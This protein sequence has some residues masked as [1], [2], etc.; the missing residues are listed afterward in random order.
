MD[1]GV[2]DAGLKFIFVS[3]RSWSGDLV[4]AGGSPGSTGSANA[5]FLCNTLGRDAGLGWFTAL[6]T[7]PGR[8]L[9]ASVPADGPWYRTDGVLVFATRDELLRGTPRV[10]INLDE[11]G[12]APGGYGS[13]WTGLT[14][15]VDG[16]LTASTRSCDRWSTSNAGSLGTAGAY[17]ATN[18]T[19]LNIG[20]QS[21]TGASC[22]TQLHLYCIGY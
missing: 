5:S 1:A 21:G 14:F 6:I 8:N 13:V 4:A 15:G 10:P 19:W 7:E 20:F 17:G 22:S 2:P 3:S 11:R 9:G 12:L 16:G 18:P